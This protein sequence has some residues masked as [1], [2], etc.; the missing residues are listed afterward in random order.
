MSSTHATQLRTVDDT[1]PPDKEAVGG[2]RL[3]RAIEVT[4]RV[5]KRDGGPARRPRRMENR[6]RERELSGRRRALRSTTTR[7]VERH[8]GYRVAWK[9]TRT[10]ERRS[11]WNAVRMSLGRRLRDIV[12]ALR[13]ARF[14]AP[15]AT[16]PKDAG[17]Y[18]GEGPLLGSWMR[19]AERNRKRA[20]AAEAARR[21]N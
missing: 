13:A 7:F 19:E 1:G 11:P 4:D 5:L 2:E 14:P 16:K 8:S 3:L 9:G 15:P 10:L 6:A 12:S 18:T 21:E 17:G 20:E